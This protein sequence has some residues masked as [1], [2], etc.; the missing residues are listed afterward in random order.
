CD[1][2]AAL[3]GTA[4]S[5][6]REA[7]D[8][9]ARRGSTGSRDPA[10]AYAGRESHHHRATAD[11]QSRAL[12]PLDG[13][14]PRATLPAYATRS[15]GSGLRTFALRRG[16][17]IK[18]HWGLLRAAIIAAPG[19][20]RTDRHPVPNR[21]QGETSPYLQQHAANPVDWYPW[22]SRRSSARGA[23]TSRF[24]FR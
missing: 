12:A 3:V 6:G 7:A 13:L 14:R 19:S 1:Q 24:C 21:L 2:P 15:A 16:K 20:L 22:G 5:V 8:H 9:D 10:R 17:K 18:E 4:G 23:R 11:F